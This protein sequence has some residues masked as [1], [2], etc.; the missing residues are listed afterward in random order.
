MKQHKRAEKQHIAV[1]YKEIVANYSIHI[2]HASFSSHF[3]VNSWVSQ[4][5]LIFST[6]DF[7]T[8]FWQ[9]HTK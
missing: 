2:T 3:Q 8:K 5:P 6:S 7:G 4:L 1:S 9:K